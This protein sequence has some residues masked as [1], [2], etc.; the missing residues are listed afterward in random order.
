MP[1]FTK[2]TYVLMNLHYFYAKVLTRLKNN[3][4]A[5]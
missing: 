1:V 2:H 5:Y 3:D 4:V